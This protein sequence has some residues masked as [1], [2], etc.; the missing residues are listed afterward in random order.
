VTELTELSEELG[1]E[2]GEAGSS[3]HDVG[4]EEWQVS[5]RREGSLHVYIAAQHKIIVNNNQSH[6]HL[7]VGMLCFAP[8]GNDDCSEH[9]EAPL[10]QSRHSR[11]PAAVEAGKNCLRAQSRNQLC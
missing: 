10:R 4:D 2:A 6:Q 9:A 7:C 1:R 3:G 5:G 8:E 11:H